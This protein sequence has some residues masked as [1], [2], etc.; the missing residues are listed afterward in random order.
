MRTADAEH[1]LTRLAEHPE[2]R[3][4]L[5]HIERIP[6]REGRTAAWPSWA[7]PRL[8][9]HLRARGIERPWT[10][11]ALAAAHARAGHHVV[12]ATGTA[13]GKSLAY[14]LPALTAIGAREVLPAPSISAYPSVNQDVALVVDREVPAAELLGTV[15]RGAGE[16]LESAEV[17]D[18]YEGKGIPDG[19]KSV[20]IALRFRAPDRTLTAEE[21]SQ[22]RE[23]AVAGAREAHGAELR[24]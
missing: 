16:L 1:L 13:S 17:F 7:D 15:R 21:A 23:D 22:A 4:C 18:V 10:H 24:G 12:V 20:A 9:E 11:Q 2:R 5:T 3:R 14:L 8:I 6:P 19:K